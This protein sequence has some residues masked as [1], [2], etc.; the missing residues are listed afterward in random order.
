MRADL[1]LRLHGA[2]ELAAV[3]ALEAV[4]EE[5]GDEVRRG[6]LHAQPVLEVVRQVALR[7]V[8]P[9]YQELVRV[10]NAQR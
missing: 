3:G 10:L 9:Q 8:Q 6:R 2:A 1:L 4:V 5:L 7:L